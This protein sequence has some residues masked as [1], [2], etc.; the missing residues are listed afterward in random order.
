MHGHLRLLFA[1]FLMFV[2]AAWSIL[3]PRH[4][5][6]P[7]LPTEIYRMLGIVCLGA[8]AFFV[9]TFFIR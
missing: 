7:Y 8:A 3:S 5:L 6:W 4:R 2:V 9:Y 1:A